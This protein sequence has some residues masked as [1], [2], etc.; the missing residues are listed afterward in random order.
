MFKLNVETYPESANV[1]DSLSDAYIKAGDKE[2]A[3]FY[4][5]KTLEIIP[6]DKKADK[7]T[8]DTLRLGALDKLKDL[9]KK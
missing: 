3:I 1:Y 5:K 8:L 9:E 7:A 4:C 6:L 2:R